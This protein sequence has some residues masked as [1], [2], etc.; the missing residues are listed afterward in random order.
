MWVSVV[1]EFGSY[2]LFTLKAIIVGDVFTWLNTQGDI[3][4]LAANL[5]VL[6]LLHRFRIRLGLGQHLGASTSDKQTFLIY[7]SHISRRQIDF[8]ARLEIGL[9]LS[10]SWHRGYSLCLFEQK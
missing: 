1:V 2:R 3:Q 9:Q 7:E 6:G 5:T 4:I 8:I 10:R